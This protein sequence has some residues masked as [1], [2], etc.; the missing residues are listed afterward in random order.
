MVFHGWGPPKPHIKVLQVQ[1]LQVAKFK[2][3]INKKHHNAIGM[4]LRSLWGYGFNRGGYGIKGKNNANMASRHMQPGETTRCGNPA[5]ASGRGRYKVSHNYISRCPPSHWPPKSFIFLWNS[6]HFALHTQTQS[7]FIFCP[8]ALSSGPTDHQ[9]PLF[10][11]GIPW[12]LLFIL[13]PTLGS[14]SANSGCL[15]APM[16][17]ETLR[18]LMESLAIC[19]PYWGRL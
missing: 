3:D 15:P 8:F 14:F 12:V 1:I 11:F 6:L 13:M 5:R 10:S 19:F 18:F 16:T 9:S 7:K 17:T 2:I 4:V